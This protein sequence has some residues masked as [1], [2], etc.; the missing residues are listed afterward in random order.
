M[1]AVTKRKVLYIAF[2][3]IPAGLFFLGSCLLA[4]ASFGAL[5]SGRSEEWGGYG[6]FTVFSFFGA[7]IGYI[8]GVLTIINLPYPSFQNA[9]KTQMTLIAIGV[10]SMIWIYKE[11]ELDTFGDSL[12]MMLLM[13][14]P[15]IVSALLMVE[16]WNS[17]NKSLNTDASDAGAG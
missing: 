16:L 14:S 7:C 4:A 10:V 1:I 12:Y 17:P 9:Q 2:G 11:F 5:F 6:I 8:T 13:I 15:L 3:A